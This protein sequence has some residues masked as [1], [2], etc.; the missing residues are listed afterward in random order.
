MVGTLYRTTPSRDNVPPNDRWNKHLV[1]E[2]GELLIE[3]LRWLGG[4][5]MLN[6]GA[7]RCLPLEREK[8]SGGLLAP[9]FEHVVWALRS[10]AL[11]PCSDGDY[12]SAED[13]RLSRTQDLRDLFNQDQLG[14]LLK[15][16]RPKKWLSPEITAD[17]T[18]ALR[19][20]LIHELKLS[21]QTPE[22]LL[23]RLNASFLQAQSDE[24]VVRLYE[25]LNK[26]P[27]LA[28]R[29]ED[30]PLVRLE[31]GAHVLAFVMGQPQ[32]FLPT[33]TETEFPTVRRSV[34]A[35]PQAKK[36]LQ[37]LN[38]TE[39][40]P[41]DDVIRNLLPKY[42]KRRLNSEQYA[43]DIARIL[44][45]FQ[46]DS[47]ARKERL[48]SSLNLTPFV[49]AKDAG[50][51]SSSLQWPNHIYLATARLRELFRGI[52]RVDMVDDSY[53]CLRGE[54]VRELLEACG[55]AR[56]IYPVEVKSDLS[57]V[58]KYKLRLAKGYVN[59]TQESPLEDY[60]LRGLTGLLDQLPTLTKEARAKKA[61]LLWEALIELQD[62]RGQSVFSGTYRWQYHQIRSASF[63]A[64]FVRQLNRSAWVPDADGDLQP[65]SSILFESLGWPTDPFLL[66]KIHFK[67]PIVEELAR[68]AG[69]EPAMLDMLKKLGLTSTAEL[70]ARLKVNDLVAQREDDRSK[71]KET[72]RSDDP[73]ED[74]TTKSR[75][76]LD[77]DKPQ[78]KER[79]APEAESSRNGHGSGGAGQGDDADDKVN[80]EGSP[81][82]GP[83]AIHRTNNNDGERTFVSYVATH[84]LSDDDSGDLEDIDHAE[85]L[86]LE[87]RAIEFIRS[88]EPLL[89]VM[90][91]GNKGFDLVET[92]VN[93]EPERWIE[94]KAMK[95]SLE[96]RPVG[97][98]SVQFEFA[99]QH[100]EQ[101]W[102]YI[103]EHA[104]DV[105]R[106]RIVKIGNPAGR[107]GTFTFDKGWI[108]IADV[109]DCIPAS[110]PTRTMG[111]DGR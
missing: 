13:V 29:L 66:S 10:E 97:L 93:N 2:T 92:D 11:L 46:T 89:K 53:H 36:Y 61:R 14:L 9:L 52:P 15:S 35:R 55:A 37:S 84:P 65:P 31:D 59:A 27:A 74:I 24:W 20:Y 98:S 96:D 68:E 87:N 60:G 106:S 40:D 4:R 109:D 62:R 70:M 88:R 86:A 32:A 108:S 30:V 103:V 95:G 42:R 94:V 26:V 38:L 77:D 57:D 12:A 64:H 82:D 1:R 3:A 49:M 34:C 102:L 75:G 107:A 25:F 78:Y 8:F 83:R 18:P 111:A 45:A 101:Y 81:H 17:R 73:Q 23:P 47:A 54:E 79:T 63:D 5:K 85:R 90:P 56:Y 100:G 43:A 67:K 58:E 50:D 48:T 69:F 99:R 105:A 22:L 76:R 71:S 6:T 33:D 19:Q 80:D 72:R 21:E 44:H 39:P 51:G 41:V 16:E 7:L 28:D 91:A 110:P 104:G